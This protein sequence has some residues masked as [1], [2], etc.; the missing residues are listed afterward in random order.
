M[1]LLVNGA[2]EVDGMPASRACIPDSGPKKTDEQ[3]SKVG[4][5]KDLR[6]ICKTVRDFC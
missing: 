5:K 2:L 6:T 4:L 1:T 3:I